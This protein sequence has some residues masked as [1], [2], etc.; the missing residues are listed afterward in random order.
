[1]PPL[2][3]RRRELDDDV[4]DDAGDD[5]GEG[6]DAGGCGEDM[7]ELAAWQLARLG[8]GDQPRLER[9][10]EDGV[11]DAAEQPAGREGEARLQC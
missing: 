6:V 9:G 11:R 3:R 5:G 4:A 8:L 7:G 1:V 2:G 10:E